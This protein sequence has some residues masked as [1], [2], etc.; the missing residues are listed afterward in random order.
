[1]I[2]TLRDSEVE[3][4]DAFATRYIRIGNDER[5]LGFDVAVDD[6]GRMRDPS[7]DAS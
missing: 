1:L 7:A 3:E 4:L 5:V 2:A 6:A